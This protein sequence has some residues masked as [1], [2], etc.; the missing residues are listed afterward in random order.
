M[1]SRFSSRHHK[2]LLPPSP[3]FTLLQS[4]TNRADPTEP[5]QQR[6]QRQTTPQDTSKTRTSTSS[7][8]TPSTCDVGGACGSVRRAAA[9]AATRGRGRASERWRVGAR[10]TSTTAK[11]TAACKLRHRRTRPGLQCPRAQR[12]GCAG[13][14][15]GM[16]GSQRFEVSSAAAAGG[17]CKMHASM[18]AGG[19]ASC[20][21]IHFNTSYCD[22][23]RRRRAPATVR[24]CRRATVQG[25]LCVCGRQRVC[26]HSS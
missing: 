3:A 4:Q 26:V 1:T 24:P 7:S 12:P 13:R 5:T 20:A 21:A 16:P 22:K 11:G 15:S 25:L 18:R 10:A 23:V 19:A 14:K 6:P 2:Y 17:R 9:A 8:R